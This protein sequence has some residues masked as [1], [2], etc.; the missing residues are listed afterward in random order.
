MS[1]TRFGSS[2]SMLSHPFHDETVERMGHL[3]AIH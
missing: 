3:A 2:R 1:D